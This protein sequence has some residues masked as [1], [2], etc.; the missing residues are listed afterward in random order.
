VAQGGENVWYRP[1]FFSK[2]HLDQ[3]VDMSVRGKA[4]LEVRRRRQDRYRRAVAAVMA[5][6]GGGRGDAEVRVPLL[7]LLYICRIRCRRL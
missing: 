1:W 3:V 5:A 7:P 4:M 6:R 2:A